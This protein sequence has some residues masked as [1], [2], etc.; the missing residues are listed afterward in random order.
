VAQLHSFLVL[1]GFYL[2]YLGFHDVATS[3]RRDGS[4]CLR[5]VLAAR[6]RSIAGIRS[7]AGL[8]AT[9]RQLAGGEERLWAGLSKEGIAIDAFG[10][11]N[12]FE[13]MTDLTAHGG[14]LSPWGKRPVLALG[15]KV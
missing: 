14:D 9:R 1:L 4:T 2:I 12:W 6:S 5:A 11:Q 8:R 13:Y 10:D 7:R 15:L 3:R